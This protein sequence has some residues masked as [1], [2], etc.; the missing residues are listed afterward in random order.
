MFLQENDKKSQTF[1]KKKTKRHFYA[2]FHKPK[3]W[4]GRLV[5]KTI[6]RLITLYLF[7]NSNIN[8]TDSQI[9]QYYRLIST[10]YDSRTNNNK[11][12]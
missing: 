2:Q 10:I 8:D 12:N 9:E 6:A 7:I 3:T 4:K 5:N 11:N 1:L